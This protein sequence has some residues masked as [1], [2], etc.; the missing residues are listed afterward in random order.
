MEKY[1]VEFVNTSIAITVSEKT[2]IFEAAQQAKLYHT[3]PCLNPAE[4]LGCP[5]KVIEGMVDYPAERL[6]RPEGENLLLAC[7]A[8]ILSS[9]KISLQNQPDPQ[10]TNPYQFEFRFPPESTKKGILDLV[11]VMLDPNDLFSSLE[12]QILSFW[13]HSALQH[14]ECDYEF[15]RKLAS[16]KK[17]SLCCVCLPGRLKVLHVQEKPFPYYGFAAILGH[18]QIEF[19][20][21]NLSTRQVELHLIKPYSPLKKT[22]LNEWIAYGKKIAPASFFGA[23]VVAGTQKEMQQLL[24]LPIP[25]TT[26]RPTDCGK[27]QLNEISSA[28]LYP[29]QPGSDGSSSLLNATSAYF[30]KMSGNHILVDLSEGFVLSVSAQEV[31]VS[32][33]SP[34][35]ERVMNSE[36]SSLEAWLTLFGHIYQMEKSPSPR[37]WFNSAHTSK[38]S[39]PI[40]GKVPEE[41]LQRLREFTAHFSGTQE[42]ILMALQKWN[43]LW[44]VVLAFSQRLNQPYQLWLTGKIKPPELTYWKKIQLVDPAAQWVVSPALQGILPVFFDLEAFVAL[45]TQTIL[46]VH[47]NEACLTPL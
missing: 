4:C 25:L 37:C 32:E 7:R 47:P 11:S 28:T 26:T 3:S 5:I 2:S 29:I 10:K 6:L 1:V 45:E 46:I 14:L 17:A 27:I 44:Q 18:H 19:A 42:E 33:A 21:L 20:L 13:N 41:V 23:G 15:L 16:W 12:N 30:K 43:W 39:P 35:P 22:L 8:K 31:F 40:S 36:G 24:G 9:C 34:F 38:S